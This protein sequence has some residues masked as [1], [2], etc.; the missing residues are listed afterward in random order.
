MLPNSV[1]PV[2]DTVTQL[3]RSRIMAATKSKDTRPEWLVRRLAHSLGY[4]YRLHVRGLP[5]T[6]D[7]VFPR[8]RKII[9]VNG[10]FW[11]LHRCAKCRVPRSRRRFWAAKLAGNRRR[12]RRNARRLRALGWGVLTVWECQMADAARLAA[13]LER[14]LGPPPRRTK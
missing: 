1:H 3:E 7:L 9:R 13:R 11:H 14:F 8:R 2:A 5:G 10:C 6:P 12:D 4:R